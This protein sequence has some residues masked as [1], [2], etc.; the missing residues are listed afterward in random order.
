MTQGR[1]MGTSYHAK[2]VSVSGVD[3]E[4][5]VDAIF[6]ALREVDDLMSTYSPDSEISRLNQVAPGEWVDVSTPTLEVAELSRRLWKLTGG[7]FDPTVGALVNLWGFGPDRRPEDLPSKADIESLRAQ[8]GYDKVEIRKT[9]PGLMK[10]TPFKIDF[11]A[12]AKGYAVDRAAAAMERLG[13]HNYLIEVGGEVRVKGYKAQGKPWQLAVEA[14]VENGRIPRRIIG[15]TNAAVATSG[16]Y[17]NYFDKGN[18]RYS[19]TIDPRT[20]YPVEHKLVSVTVI[21]DSVGFAD[22]L[23]TGMMV[24]GPEQGFDLAVKNGWA[25]YFIIKSP[26]GF[27]DLSTPAFDKVAKTGVYP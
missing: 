16:S 4:K 5:V 27:V 10:D 20:G 23:A 24:L 21:S 2:W 17:R 7:A 1:V 9:P 3:D 22:G 15:L 14:P 25:V 6:D 26:D 8:I 19:H 18:K 12:V 13:V 11:S